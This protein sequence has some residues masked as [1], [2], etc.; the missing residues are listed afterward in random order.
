MSEHTL[1]VHCPNGHTYEVEPTV[2]H[3]EVDYVGYSSDRDFC[4]VCDEMTD[5]GDTPFWER[6]E[7][8]LRAP[9]GKEAR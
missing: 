2:V 9:K 5:G 7:A 3:P 4:I 1:T 8:L 6:F